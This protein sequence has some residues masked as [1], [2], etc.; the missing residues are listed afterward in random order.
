MQGDHLNLIVKANAKDADKPWKRRHL[1][2]WIAPPVQSTGNG[3][4]VAA[5]VKAL[6]EY[7]DTHHDI[8]K[9]PIGEDGVLG[10][11]WAQIIRDVR[12]LLN[13]DC[14]ELD[15]GTVDGILAAMLKNEGFSE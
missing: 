15:C 13:G 11:H 6:S 7:A 8:Y 4:A 5:L 9:A 3:H 12:G 1:A 14:G 10:E 2:A